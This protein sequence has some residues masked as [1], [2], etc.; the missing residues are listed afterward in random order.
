MSSSRV[1]C[2]TYLLVAILYTGYVFGANAP[3]VFLKKNSVPASVIVTVHSVFVAF[4]LVLLKVTSSVYPLMPDWMTA[5]RTFSVPVN[6]LFLIVGIFLQ[7]IESRLIYRE[8][9]EGN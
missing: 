1:S 5:G 4:A 7:K 3:W 8:S 2:W 9:R 6:V